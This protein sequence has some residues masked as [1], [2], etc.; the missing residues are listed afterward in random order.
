M[1]L[2][3]NILPTKSNNQTGSDR[4]DAITYGKEKKDGGHDHRTNKGTDRTRSQ[5]EGDKKRRK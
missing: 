5:Q 3:D 4:L 2:F 1:G